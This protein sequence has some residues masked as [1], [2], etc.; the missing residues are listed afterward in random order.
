MT[1]L[2][3]I[4]EKAKTHLGKFTRAEIKVSVIFV[5]TLIAVSAALYIEKDFSEYYYDLYEIS[6]ELLG[7][8]RASA[9]VGFMGFIFVS[10]AEKE[11]SG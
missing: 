2:K 1:D 3:K 8:A 9:G 5:L 11:Y 4:F 6:F 7:A 10:C